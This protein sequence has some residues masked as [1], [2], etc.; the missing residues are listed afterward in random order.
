MPL[1]PL[2]FRIQLG[3]V[4]EQSHRPGM[5]DPDQ[6]MEVE[7]GQMRMKE[8]EEPLWQLQQRCETDEKW[9]SGHGGVTCGTPAE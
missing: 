1:Q 5:S 8:T 4:T 6:P 7:M 3:R 9:G 2:C